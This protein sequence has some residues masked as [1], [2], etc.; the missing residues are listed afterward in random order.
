MLSRGHLDACRRKVVHHQGNVQRIALDRGVMGGAEN[1]L[2]RAHD[3]RAGW[4][5]VRSG[6]D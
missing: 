6:H 4:A 3:A 2:R 1:R 5:M